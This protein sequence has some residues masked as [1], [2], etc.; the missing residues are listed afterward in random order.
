MQSA[1][2]TETQEQPGQQPK[3]VMSGIRLAVQCQFGKVCNGIDLCVPEPVPLQAYD[4]YEFRRLCKEF[5]T[6]LL[7]Q[8]L[9]DIEHPGI[10]LPNAERPESR[11]QD[12]VRN[13]P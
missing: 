11:N 6:Y 1:I 12:P 5:M 13:F 8:L 3:N 9:G 7:N 4:K 10:H 2:A